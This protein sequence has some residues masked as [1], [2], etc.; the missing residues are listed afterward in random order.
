ME[1]LEIVIC[2][3]LGT[4]QIKI[5]AFDQNLHCLC[6]FIQENQLIYPA[7]GLIEQ[8][9]NIFFERS[10]NLLQQVSEALGNR[11]RYVRAIVGSGQMAGIM[12]IDRDWDPIL[13]YYSILDPRS[14]RF[15]SQIAPHLNHILAIG[16]G[17]THQLEKILFWLSDFRD[18]NV[19]LGKFITPQ[20]YV[21]GK[22]AG[23][24]SDEAYIDKTFSCVNGL[25]DVTTW[26]WEPGLLEAFEIPAK[27][28][29]KICDSDTIIGSIDP[30]WA[31]SLNFPGDVAIL[32]GSG[33]GV[34]T[35]SGAGVCE[36]GMAIDLSG[37][38]CAFSVYID[39]F[40]ADTQKE[41]FMSIKSPIAPGWYLSYV[42]QFGR[43]HRWFVEEFFQDLLDENDGDYDK[44]YGLLDQRSAAI[45]PGCNGTFF[46]PHLSGRGQPP[47]GYYR[48]CF[49]GFGLGY[50]RAHFYRSMLESLPFEYHTVVSEMK[51]LGLLTELKEIVILGGGS[52]SDFWNQLK[53]DILDVKYRRITDSSTIT[54]RGDAMIAAKALNWPVYQHALDCVQIDREYDP[55]PKVTN[56]YS[57]VAPSYKQFDTDMDKT[58]RHL[59]S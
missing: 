38:A 28:L 48:G 15:Q 4:T 46:I 52:K 36:V 19:S 3:D 1:N 12:A 56:I 50:T 8:D 34:A 21:M 58:F 26:D 35:F 20:V 57:Q 59:F 18:H 27:Y 5:A 42:N 25:M 17:V 53:A 47:K 33:D 55:H 29:P 45:E 7:P 22:L 51:E 31:R 10:F 11:S 49:A 6:T 16:G 40:Y 54:L 23:L 24:S 37:T 9:P 43:S 44:V 30:E 13:N 39:Q 32:A 14:N 2:L 41:L